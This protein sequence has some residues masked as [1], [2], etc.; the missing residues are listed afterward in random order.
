MTTTTEETPTIPADL[1]TARELV[2]LRSS[3]TINQLTELRRSGRLPHWRM[4][5]TAYFRLADY[6]ALWTHHPATR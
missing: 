5:R 2:E 6:D 1:I 4:G 3:A